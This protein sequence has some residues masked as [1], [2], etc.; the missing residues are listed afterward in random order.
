MKVQVKLGTKKS[1][2]FYNFDVEKEYTELQKG[3]MPH[4]VLQILAD[5]EKEFPGNFKGFCGKRFISSRLMRSDIG[6]DLKFDDYGYQV[7]L[8]SLLKD[9]L[10]AGLIQGRVR[11]ADWSTVKITSLGKEFLKYNIKD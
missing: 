2:G 11:T 9:F 7:S 1:G 6:E 4:L 5:L 10:K 8:N 3:R